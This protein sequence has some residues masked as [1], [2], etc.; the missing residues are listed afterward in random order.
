MSPLLFFFAISICPSLIAE[1][2]PDPQFKRPIDKPWIKYGT[3]SFSYG[4]ALT[5][6]G[7]IINGAS[8]D[9]Q[10]LALYIN[11]QTI[12]DPVY[13]PIIQQVGPVYQA[14]SFKLRSDTF[15]IAY[16]S[17]ESERWTWG[18]AFRYLSIL[19]K[20]DIP[21]TFVQVD[22]YIPTANGF[23]QTTE[24]TQSWKTLATSY[25][26]DGS[27][28]YHFRPGSTWDPYLQLSL[29]VGYGYL[30]EKQGISSLIEYH[31]AV[32]GGLRINLSESYFLYSEVYAA[33]HWAETEPRSNPI[34][35]TDVLVNPE[36]GSL[37]L[38]RIVVGAGFRLN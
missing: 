34:D 25:E 8:D 3:L 12:Y 19:G 11:D 33:A 15:S 35:F 2:R 37:Y 23:Y 4:P 9:L 26:L 31:G 17:E 36:K 30:G 38:A 29:G 5:A 18:V 10:L 6:G 7:S 22:K 14:P 20:A 13:T 1:E 32:A 27:V 24:G 21:D 16:E 28:G